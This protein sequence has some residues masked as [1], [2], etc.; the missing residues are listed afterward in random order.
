VSHPVNTPAVSTS[1]ANAGG[2]A[3]PVPAVA[4]EGSSRRAAFGPDKIE[5]QSP[6]FVVNLED[7]HEVDIKMRQETAGAHLSAPMHSLEAKD[8]TGSQNAKSH[9]YQPMKSSSESQVF[10]PG[11]LTLELVR[12]PP[13]PAHAPP[14]HK[15]DGANADPNTT[16]SEYSMRNPYPPPHPQSQTLKAKRG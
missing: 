13:L 14:Q 4:V 11:W 7:S 10:Q 5:R 12:R 1:P 2:G 15:E 6:A 3:G 9:R 8:T 16:S